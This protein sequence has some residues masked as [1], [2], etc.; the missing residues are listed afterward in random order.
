MD[1]SNRYRLLKLLDE[2]PHLTQRELA[3]NMGV[4]LGKANYCLRALIEVGIIK[5]NNFKNAANKAAYLYTLTPRG[6]DEKTKVT[7]RF[8]KRKIAEY[9]SILLEIDELRAD[10]QQRERYNKEEI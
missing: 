10:V 1:D 6:I 3:K 8:L 9:E 4:S 5:V 7:H 2:Q